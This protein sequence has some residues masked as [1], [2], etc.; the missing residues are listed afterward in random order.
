M[1]VLEL[2]EACIVYAFN[3]S[4]QVDV[5]IGEEVVFLQSSDLRPP[6]LVVGS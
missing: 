4:V 5:G 2:I 3:K 1:K 6:I